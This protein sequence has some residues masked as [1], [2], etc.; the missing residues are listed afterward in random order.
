MR[1]RQSPSLGMPIGLSRGGASA[2][3]LIGV[4]LGQPSGPCPCPSGSALRL[5]PVQ[6]VRRRQ[7]ALIQTDMDTANP[8]QGRS[9]GSRDSAP[10][11]GLFGPTL[12]AVPMSIWLG[13]APPTCTGSRRVRHAHLV[14]SMVRTAHPTAYIHL[15]GD[16]PDGTGPTPYPPGRP[17]HGSGGRRSRSRPAPAYCSP[18]ASSSG[19]T[20]S[21]MPL[22]WPSRNICTMM[23]LPPTSSP[24]IQS[25][26]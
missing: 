26:G 21:I 3:P 15:G 17:L 11:R 5:L 25:W 23:S 20:S 2:P 12:R 4:C 14:C 10:D 9:R 19:T 1:L 8:N 16:S 6:A 22:S 24:L 13:V 18:E 7:R